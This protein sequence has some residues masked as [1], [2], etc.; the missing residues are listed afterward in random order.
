[1]RA[2]GREEYGAGRGGRVGAREEETVGSV[3]W[4]RKQGRLTVAFGSQPSGIMLLIWCEPLV[5]YTRSW[6]TDAWDLVTD[7]G[8]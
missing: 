8:C 5:G 7:C 1:M 2:G 4:I 3:V 6:G